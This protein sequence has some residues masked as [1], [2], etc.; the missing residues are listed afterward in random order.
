MTIY[1]YP[2]NIN[3]Y[4]VVIM[5][6]GAVILTVQIQNGTPC[7]WAKVNPEEMPEPRRIRIFGTGHELTTEESEIYIGTFQIHGGS[8][9][10][11][12]FEMFTGP[13]A[14]GVK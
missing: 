5:P 10:F 2:L 9:V 8:L 1:K 3:E 13:S 4:Q 12:V 11:H 14:K 6:R 7:L